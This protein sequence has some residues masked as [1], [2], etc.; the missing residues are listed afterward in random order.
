MK[1]FNNFII[2]YFFIL[3]D[4]FFILYQLSFPCENAF[5]NSNNASYILHLYGIIFIQLLYSIIKYL[6]KF[7]L[8]TIMRQESLQKFYLKLYSTTTMIIITFVV[9]FN[10]TLFLLL[11]I[12]QREIIISDIPYLVDTIVLQILFYSIVSQLYLWFYL[13][14]F[15]SKTTLFSTMVFYYIFAFLA[16]DFENY[17]LICS[18]SSSRQY[19]YNLIYANIILF[20]LIILRKRGDVNIEA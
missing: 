13:K 16:P 6:S 1:R 15:K 3:F 20:T 4:I 8:F 19:Y 18:T 2:T 7:N 12:F 17:I 14:S 5:I 11:S 9:L 10:I